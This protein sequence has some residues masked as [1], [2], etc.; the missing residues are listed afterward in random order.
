[1]PA[2]AMRAATGVTGAVLLLLGLAAWA[3]PVRLGG[4]LGL[5]GIAPLGHATLRADLGAF[6]ITAGALALAG[7]FRRDRALLLAPF[8][9]MALALLGRCLALA[10]TPFDPAMVPPML[11]EALMAAALGA[12]LRR[13]AL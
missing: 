7:T 1:M 4:S 11:A 12:G 9:L 10:F 3:D 5:A 13:G 8:L 6:F 2:L